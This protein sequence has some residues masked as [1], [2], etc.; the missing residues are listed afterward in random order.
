M[1]G[2][3]VKAEVK[4]LPLVLESAPNGG[5]EHGVSAGKW[6]WQESIVGMTTMEEMCAC[7]VRPLPVD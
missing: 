3:L 7:D 2:I 1:I 4:F 5:I 6:F